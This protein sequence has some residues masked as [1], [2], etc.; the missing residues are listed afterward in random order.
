M[1][2]RQAELS[3]LVKT[4]PAAKKKIETVFDNILDYDSLAKGSL[5]DNWDARSEA[6]RREFQDVLKQLVQRAYRRNL[7]RTA[8]YE[9]RFDGESPEGQAFRV[10]TVAQSRSNEREEPVSIDYVVHKAGATW[11][12]SDIVTEGSSLVGTYRQQF[13]RVIK[14]DGFPELIRRMK[15][16][17]ATG[18]E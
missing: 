15:R 17:L 4:G 8:A 16:K 13:G 5:G 9:V 11:L 1:R 3:Q 6:E 14:K 2:G 12:I 7:D 10:K 18:A